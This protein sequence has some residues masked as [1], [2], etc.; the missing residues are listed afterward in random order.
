MLERV[1][2]RLTPSRI[3]LLKI[4]VEGSEM[5][6]FQG[7]DFNGPYRPENLIVEYYTALFPQATAVFECLQSNGY[8]AMT[9]EGKPIK[10]CKGLPGE[11]VWFRSI[12]H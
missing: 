4:N 1:L 7:L 6:V 5:S 9:V 10:E 8:E 11:N 12:R 3:K 2:E